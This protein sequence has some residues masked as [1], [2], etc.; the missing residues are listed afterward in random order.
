LIGY[1]FITINGEVLNRVPPKITT[2]INYQIIQRHDIEEKEFEHEEE[3]KKM[4]KDIKGYLKNL[5]LDPQYT[6]IMGQVL[7]IK[8]TPGLEYV[9]AIFSGGETE[10][11]LNIG[12][13]PFRNG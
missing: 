3:M 6:K 1:I 4:N 9:P 10:F 12:R 11:N 7:E 5:D 2:E 8:M 13:S